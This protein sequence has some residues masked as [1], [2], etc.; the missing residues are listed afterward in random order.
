MQ[1]FSSLPPPLEQGGSG[2]QP[3]LCL[4]LL[5]TTLQNN[6]GPQNIL[7]PPAQNRG[8]GSKSDLSLKPACESQA[9]AHD[10]GHFVRGLSHHTKL[11]KHTE[12]GD[13]YKLPPPH[14]V[15]LLP[16]PQYCMWAIPGYQLSLGRE[17]GW[18]GACP[19]PPVYLFPRD[20]LDQSRGQRSPP[21]FLIHARLLRR[22]AGGGRRVPYSR[23]PVGGPTDINP[24]TPTKAVLSQNL[25]QPT[26]SLRKD[27]SYGCRERERRRAAS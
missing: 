16:R 3:L 20:S 19:P 10:L 7:W 21:P 2:H 8:P 14:P 6:E 27:G 11:P 1:T 22:R 15:T 5:S 24:G 13:P 25:T 17:A 12:G 26:T 9:N 23:G 18:G 4:C